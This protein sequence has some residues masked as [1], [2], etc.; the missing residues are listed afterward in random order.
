[1]PS[2]FER[3]LFEMTGRDAEAVRKTYDLYKQA[4][5]A[6]LPEVAVSRLKCSGLS[7]DSVSND[8]TLA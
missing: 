8:E 3:L 5:E 2:N 4:G 6:P 1:M 7:A